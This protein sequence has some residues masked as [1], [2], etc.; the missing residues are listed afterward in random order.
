MDIYPVILAG[1]SGTRFWPVS[2]RDHPK[3]LLPLI[4]DRSMLRMTVDLLQKLFDPASFRV[5]TPPHLRKKVQKQLPE[6]QDECF[7]HEPAPRDTAP[8]IGLAA[9]SIHEENHNGAMFVVPSDHYITEESVYLRTISS[10]VQT[11]Q[12]H[13][14]QLITFGLTPNKPATEYGY[15][16]RGELVESRNGIPIH[17][18]RSFTE[19]PDQEQAEEYFSSNSFLWNS[20][21]FLWKASVILGRIRSHAPDVF[22]G[23]SSYVETCSNLSAPSAEA[24]HNFVQIP[25]TSID[26][27][28]MEHA[29]DV[30]VV[31]SDFGWH[32]IGTW[33]ALPDA[34]KTDE[35][36]NLVEGTTVID[37]THNTVVYNTEADHLVAALHTDELAIIHTEDATLVCPLDEAQR[38]K[39]LV[40]TLEKKGLHQYL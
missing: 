18:V 6:L 28:V 39:Q 35:Y 9:Q 10:A 16:H 8:C 38:V 2:R 1:G 17:T 37:D 29:D 19:K 30:M 15:I 25:S 40:K 5:V 3:Q 22:S 12:K 27:A 26:Y 24:E 33:N 20:G 36:G 31:E 7:L 23:L 14:E 4:D 32:D 34:L 21:M 13:P 11:L